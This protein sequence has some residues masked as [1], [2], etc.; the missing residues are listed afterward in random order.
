MVIWFLWLN[1]LFIFKLRLVIVS[2]KGWG[3]LYAWIER[4]GKHDQKRK[5]KIGKTALL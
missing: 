2:W 1:F 5:K 4:E 3:V